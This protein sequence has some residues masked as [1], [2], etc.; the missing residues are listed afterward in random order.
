MLSNKLT[1]NQSLLLKAV[2]REDSQG[3]KAWQE[4]SHSIDLKKID[5]G[6]Y[7]LLSLLY[8]NLI[9][10]KLDHP[11][12]PKLKGIFRHTWYIN[13]TLLSRALPI[14]KNLEER[15]IPSLI[16]K[17]ALIPLR[18]PER[19]HAYPIFD[20]DILVPTDK[21]HHAIS[22]LMKLGWKKQYYVSDE[23][24]VA[25]QTMAKFSNREGL[26]L[27][28]HWHVLQE[29]KSGDE[30]TPFWNRA[31]VLSAQ[32]DQVRSLSLEDHILYTIN[33][34]AHNLP[35]RWLADLAILLKESH[36]EIDWEKL[37]QSA[38]AYDLTA[39][40][41]HTLHYL[42]DSLAIH[43]P[44]NILK[45]K[46]NDLRDPKSSLPSVLSFHWNQYKERSRQKEFLKLVW[47]LPAYL[48]A[49]WDFR[50]TWS[51]PLVALQKIAYHFR[52]Y[53]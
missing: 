2:L 8:Q 51:W 50:H 16:L 37:T 23:E 10:Q 46:E 20:F 33:H 24:K 19:Y 53:H 39:P 21:I 34:R 28:L 6:S 36:D 25:F 22:L 18:Y 43:V 42:Q 4:W 9:A 49:L 13:R 38:K 40:L 44:R 26:H 52:S 31:I 3:K 27:N 11:T 15:H 35:I 45:C 48:Q 12:L 47:G 5:P 17:R 41:N 29:F 1:N 32:D 14:L 30:D 7:Q